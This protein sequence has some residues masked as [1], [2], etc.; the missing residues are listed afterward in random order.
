MKKLFLACCIAAVAASSV[1]CGTQ[2]T[3]SSTNS[4]PASSTGS[5]MDSSA[6]SEK[7][8]LSVYAM[9]NSGGQIKNY[10]EMKGLQVAAETLNMEIEYQ[11]PTTGSEADQFNLMIASKEY[12]DIIFWI[13]K[14]TPM[15]LT[16]LLDEGIAINA[17]E[18]IREYAPNYLAQLAKDP[19]MDKQAKLSDGTYPG[20][21]KL[22]PVPIRNA[23]KGL[24]LRKDQFDKM[25]LTV[26][27]TIDDWYNM[28]KTVKEADPNSIPFG[29]QKNSNFAGFLPGFG[30]LD[31]FCRVDGKVVFGPLQPSYR[32]FITTMNQWYS[33]GLIDPDFSTTDSKAFNSK[34]LNNQTFSFIGNVGGGMGNLTSQARTENADFELMAVPYPKAD[35]SMELPYTSHADMLIKAG[36]DIGVITKSCENPVAAVQYMDFFYSEEGHNLVNFGVEGESYTVVEGKN[37]Y[38]DVVLNNPDG[39]T[40][41]QAIYQ[42]AMPIH[43]WT[44]AM[45]FDAY[46]QINLVLPEQKECPNQWGNVS[47][48]LIMPPIEL[49]SEANDEYTKIMSEVTTYVSEMTLKFIMGIEPLENYDN[50]TETLQK[51]DVERATEIMQEAYDAYNAR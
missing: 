37:A 11:M 13:L 41:G 40:P 25:G 51:M 29:D 35:P 43:G 50:F 39:L 12:P 15:K 8:K 36:P 17:D 44:K 38:T 5:S 19:E 7:V 32:D 28:L 1:A 24:M 10:S 34:V 42:Y 3:E 45:D 4:T 6:S 2:T 26:P 14:N 9:N 20:L 27:E 48:D 30:V 21:Y 33:E 47:T 49:E 23:F 46:E 16:G 18:Y 31:S 22:E